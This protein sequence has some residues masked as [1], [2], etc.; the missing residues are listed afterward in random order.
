MYFKKLLGAENQSN[1][2]FRTVW[3]IRVISTFFLFF[4]QPV[5]FI[6]QR[7]PITDGPQAE[8]EQ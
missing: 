5:R 4:C 6:T 1:V 3:R 2:T 7:G 8:F